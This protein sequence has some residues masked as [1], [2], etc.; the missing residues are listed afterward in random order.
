METDVYAGRNERTPNWT[1]IL[2]PLGAVLALTLH[3]SLLPPAVVVAGLFHLRRNETMV[4]L[5]IGCGTL[6]LLG[7]GYALAK[8]AALRDNRACQKTTQQC[9]R[10]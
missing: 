8:Q 2:V 10:A 9:P 5:S 6:L 7:I 1:N 4:A 3:W